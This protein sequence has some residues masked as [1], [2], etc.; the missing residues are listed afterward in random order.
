MPTDRYGLP[1]STASA[2][3]AE[4]YRQGVDALLAALPEPQRLLQQAIDADPGFALAW[5]ALARCRWLE[6]DVAGARVAAA[7]ARERAAAA[8]A[9]EQGHVHALALAI[10]GRSADA[11]AATRE[12]LRQHPRDAL[13]LAPMTGVFGLIG[14]SGRAGREDELHDELLALS[15]HYGD[16]AWFGAMQAF[17]ECE[18]GRLAAAQARI[19]R[20]LSTWPHNAHGVHVR[21]HVLHE[22]GDTQAELDMLLQWLPAYPRRGLMHCHLSWHAAMAALALGR[23]DEAWQI[24]RD[25]VMP[26]A[27]WGPPL[28]VVTDAVSFVWR[29]GLAGAPGQADDWPRLLRHALQCFP[30][31]G[32]AFAD[33]HVAI[34]C[35]AAGDRASWQRLQGEV[36][37]AMAAGQLPAGEVLPLLMEGFAAF[38]AGDAPT[39]VARLEA[40][41]PQ[42]VRIGGS[43]AQRE[44]VAHT[45]HAARRQLGQADMA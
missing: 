30:R 36:L 32:V 9:R 1:L 15:P 10:E 6:A 33:W 5:I 34:A 35:S 41:A 25:A 21:A 37:Q 20:S 8:T 31:A 4:A 24:C 28:N 19:E 18:T 26:G 43:R 16:D 27:A 14:F 45:L 40:A 7:Q 29:A 39:A 22:R 44:L 13:V 3:A 38:A 2:A 42:L 23:S 11:L 17:A 12:Q